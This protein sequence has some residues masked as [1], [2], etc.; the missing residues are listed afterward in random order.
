MVFKLALLKGASLNLFRLSESD[1]KTE[2]TMMTHQMGLMDRGKRA[3][4]GFY[5]T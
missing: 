4:M 2:T 5:P 3:G 1:H